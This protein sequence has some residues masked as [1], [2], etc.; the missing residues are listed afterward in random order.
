MCI[1]LQKPEETSRQINGLIFWEKGIMEMYCWFLRVRTKKNPAM[2][3]I[4][5]KKK[6]KPHH[7]TGIVRGKMEE[8][9][10]KVFCLKVYSSDWLGHIDLFLNQK[11]GIA[12]NR[13]ETIEINPHKL[14]NV[15]RNP[16]TFKLQVQSFLQLQTFEK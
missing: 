13:A 8:W 6:T 2:N 1:L 5:K 12:Y 11:M 4:L 16:Q 3:E 14:F 15:I 7:F 9:K 10:R